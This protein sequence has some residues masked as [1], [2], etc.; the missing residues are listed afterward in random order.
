MGRS[1]LLL[2][3]SSYGDFASIKFSR[4]VA[5]TL[6]LNRYLRDYIELHSSLKS[7]HVEEKENS[8]GHPYLS[9][10]FVSPNVS[11]NLWLR[12][13]SKRITKIT[14]EADLELMAKDITHLVK[15]EEISA[16]DSGQKNWE[17]L[18]SGLPFVSSVT[19]KQTRKVEVVIE[20]KPTAIELKD[21][22]ETY[23]DNYAGGIDRWV[24]VGFRKDGVGGTVW[25]NKYILKSILLV[26]DIGGI[27]DTGHYTTKRL[28]AA[29]SLRRDALLAPLGQKDK[30]SVA[31]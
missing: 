10:S 5:D 13:Y 26:S 6:L 1:C 23:Q 9:V 19:S 18:L 21:I 2:V 31:A 16:I 30:D 27:N 22:L 24:N 20:A 4:S 25:L 3:Y 12:I 14:K 7:K 11:G 8:A 15:R 28:F 17:R 29:L